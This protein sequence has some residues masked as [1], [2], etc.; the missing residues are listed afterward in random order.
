MIEGR[1]RKNRMKIVQDDSSAEFSYLSIN[2]AA[3]TY[4]QNVVGEIY[5]PIKSSTFTD[6]IASR[7]ANELALNFTIA[8]VGGTSPTL[9]INF[10]VL[11]VMEP[12]N[13][14]T[15]VPPSPLPPPVLSIPI[16]QG[17]SQISSPSTVRFVISNGQAIVWINNTSTNLGPMNVPMLWQVQFTVGGSSP[18]FS[19]IG[20][21]E[22][23]K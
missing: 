8:Q 1:E 10:L 22:E 17:S 13:G 15:G 12:S 7:D 2:G 18:S 23:R 20:T 16:A 19:V 21:F 6:R 5:G 4:D 14:T 3:L 11:D 9:S